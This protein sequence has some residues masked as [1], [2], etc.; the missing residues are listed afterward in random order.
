MMRSKNIVT[1][2]KNVT[3][4]LELLHGLRISTIVTFDINLIMM[5]NDMCIFYQSELLKHDRQGRTRDKTIYKILK[6]LKLCPM[7]ATRE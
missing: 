4:L 1:I 3:T 6:N 7:A 2:F 5:S